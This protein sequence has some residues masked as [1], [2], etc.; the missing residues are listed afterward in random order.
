MTDNKTRGRTSPT[1]RFWTQTTLFR[2]QV[3]ITLCGIVGPAWT[4]REVIGCAS[5]PEASIPE[6]LVQVG[7]PVCTYPNMTLVV[8]IR[9]GEHVVGTQ[10]KWC[11]LRRAVQGTGELDATLSSNSDSILGGFP[12]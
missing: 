4:T 3:K 6:V 11:K 10:S 9:N 8:P 12:S 7:A 2:T 5:L 1:L